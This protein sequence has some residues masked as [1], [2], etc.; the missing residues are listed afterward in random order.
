[1]KKLTIFKNFHYCFPPTF[2]FSFKNMFE[3]TVIFDESCKYYFDNDDKYDINKLCG[4]RMHMF[5]NHKNSFRFGWLYNQETNL[6]DIYCYY[7]VNG[8]RDFYKINS[9]QIGKETTLKIN[10][11]K[12]KV[13]FITNN[14]LFLVSYEGRNIIKYFSTF[15]FGGNLKAPHTM[16]IWTSQH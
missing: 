10:F 15:Y 7:Y 12:N 1:M 14:R 8:K 2:K 6:I 13:E 4:L 5:T 11:L 3:W 9:V 16:F